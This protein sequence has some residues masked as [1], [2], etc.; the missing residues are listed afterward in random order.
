MM[1]SEQQMNYE[2][3][4]KYLNPCQPVGSET[5]LDV[6]LDYINDFFV[7][8]LQI[9]STFCDFVKRKSYKKVQDEWVPVEIIREEV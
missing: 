2:S 4:Q 3:D 8:G 7:L 1:D 9:L 6:V 5:Q